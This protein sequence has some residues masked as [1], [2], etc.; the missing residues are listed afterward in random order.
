MSSG[1]APPTPSLTLPPPDIHEH[2]A[3]VRE[4]LRFSANLRQEYDVP[5]E[6][7]DQ[8]VE[9]IIELLELD[10][11]ANASIGFPGFGLGVADRKR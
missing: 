5:Q 3:T 11:I 1:A 6:Q 7:K 2:T 4:A 9:D 8:F 10:D